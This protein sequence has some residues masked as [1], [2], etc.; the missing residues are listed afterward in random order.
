MWWGS[1][2]ETVSLREQRLRAGKREGKMRILG[3]RGRVR[4]RK[5]RGEGVLSTTVRPDIGSV[6]VRVR[7][8]HEERKFRLTM[9]MI[10]VRT[11]DSQFMTL[12]F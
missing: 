2:R 12:K 10:G 11:E 6:R 3:R 1:R 7:G 5:G 9:T 4:L 8:R